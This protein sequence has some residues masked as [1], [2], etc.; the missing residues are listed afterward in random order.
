MYKLY[1]CTYLCRYI[2]MYIY[3]Y[4]CNYVHMHTYA[5]V[6]DFLAMYVSD[7]NCN[8]YG[9][10][11]GRQCME[12]SELLHLASNKANG[13]SFSTIVW[14]YYQELERQWLWLLPRGWQR[15]PDSRDLG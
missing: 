3:I 9:F 5:C 13:T 12:L 7:F 8:L 2:Y 11:P 10:V 6:C 4:I 1:V 15:E 14:G